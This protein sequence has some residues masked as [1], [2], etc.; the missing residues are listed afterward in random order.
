MG[1]VLECLSDRL[2]H[3]DGGEV[4]SRGPRTTR[5]FWKRLGRVEPASE[6]EDDSMG[7]L[8]VNFARGLTV[9]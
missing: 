8:N 6:V 5:N 1:T 7:L 2:V 4:S 9:D 3:N